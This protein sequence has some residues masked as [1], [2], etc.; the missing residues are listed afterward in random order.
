MNF[1]KKACKYAFFVYI[2]IYINLRLASSNRKVRKMK[3]DLLTKMRKLNWLLQ[4]SQ[5]GTFSFREICNVLGDVMFSDVYVI[6]LKGKI[7]GSNSMEKIEAVMRKNSEN[8]VYTTSKRNNEI[9]LEFEETVAN[10]RSEDIRKEYKSV[11]DALIGEK[12]IYMVVPILGGGKRLGTLVICRDELEYDSEDIILGESGSTLMGVEI[13]RRNL[14]EREEEE[15]L[16][17]EVQLSIGTLSYSEID[18]VKRIFEN[19]SEKE[20]LL[21]ASKIADEAGITRSVIVN[22]LRK[23]QSAGLIE[24]R[25]LGMK[26]THIK[27]LNPKFTEELE[28]LNI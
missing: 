24:T 22:A 16:R 3:K 13:Q 27:V 9:L 18:A 17:T 1:S 23:L 7:I 2:I 4:E 15:R 12:N 21:V 10:R 5:T 8:G 26:G 6:D 20:G 28:K 25:S 11:D 14:A 19:F